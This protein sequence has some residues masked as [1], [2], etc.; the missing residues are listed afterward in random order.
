M[1]KVCRT[2]TTIHNFNSWCVDKYTCYVTD[3]RTG[4]QD[5]RAKLSLFVA[6]DRPTVKGN[7]CLYSFRSQIF[8]D[9]SV[10]QGAVSGVNGRSDNSQI[11][12]LLWYTKFCYFVRHSWTADTVRSKT[13]SISCPPTVVLQEIFQP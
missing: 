6:I 9:N 12:S 4:F 3:R 11:Y 5:V 13:N 8:G 2:D 10:V 7:S 1:A